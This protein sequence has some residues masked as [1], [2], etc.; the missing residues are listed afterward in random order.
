MKEVLNLRCPSCGRSRE[1]RCLLLL[2]RTR[3]SISQKLVFHSPFSNTDPKCKLIIKRSELEVCI[4]FNYSG[5]SSEACRRG[6]GR[7]VSRGGRAT[8]EKGGGKGREAKKGRRGKK[9]QGG[10]EEKE[11][12]RETKVGRGKGRKSQT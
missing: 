1:R 3:F 9:N 5:R 4:T 2:R 6:R 10:G 12:G 11:R 7:P 8:E